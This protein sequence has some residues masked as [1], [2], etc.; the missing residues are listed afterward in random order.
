VSGGA[1]AVLV[2]TLV[3]GTLRAQDSAGTAP[4]APAQAAP[5]QAPDPQRELE[6]NKVV[7]FCQQVDLTAPPTVQGARDR[8]DCWK[9]L[10]LQGMG[11]ALVDAKYQA[12]VADFDQA[13]AKDSTRK[14]SDSS[15]AAINAKMLAAQRAIQTR[16]LDDAQ[17]AVN[18]VLAIQPNNQ[19]ALVLNDRIVALQ[20]AR[21]LKITLFAVGAAVLALGAGLGFVAKKL[22]KKHTEKATQQKVTAAD[23]KA[24]LKI[25]DGVG[26]GKV[27][28]IESPLFRI[29]AASSDKP[30]EKNDLVLSDSAASISR[31]HCSII[32][33]DGRFFV[34]DSSLNGTRVND[35]PLD[36]GEHHALRDG[37]EV[38][39]AD[40]SRLKFLEM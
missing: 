26:R 5:A 38:T 12:A 21:Q 16:N 27:Y 25:V 15:A 17:T 24:M 6:R 11:D 19:R 8:T 30:E 28:T 23:R 36:R 7:Q 31:Y 2:L 40:V 37:D 10:Q 1:A 33:R 34:I 39:V 13:T 4:A 22:G 14:A 35:E 9:R 3:G 32:R 29:G 20:R 18:D